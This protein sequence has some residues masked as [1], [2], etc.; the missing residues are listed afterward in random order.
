MATEEDLRDSQKQYLVAEMALEKAKAWTPSIIDVSRL[1]IDRIND[2]YAGTK[3]EVEE[4][5]ELVF[6]VLTAVN[7]RLAVPGVWSV[8]TAAPASD[9]AIR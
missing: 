4:S 3:P 7:K 1:V 8:P 6:A 9:G 5:V 2:K